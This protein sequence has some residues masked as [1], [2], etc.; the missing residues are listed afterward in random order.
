MQNNL[1]YR[2][3]I[4]IISNLLRA[5]R[6]ILFDQPVIERSGARQPARFTLTFLHET[7]RLLVLFVLAV[8]W[9]KVEHKAK[10]NSHIWKFE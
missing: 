4:I 3:T 7:S 8:W 9:K 2:L 6:W 1:F 10:I 5:Q